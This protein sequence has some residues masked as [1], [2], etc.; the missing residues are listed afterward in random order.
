MSDRDDVKP[1]NKKHNSTPEP[2]SVNRLDTME[3]VR[4]LFP[5]ELKNPLLDEEPERLR[6]IHAKVLV[7]SRQP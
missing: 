1:K 2:E 4:A 3:Q 6:Y 7:K 5:S